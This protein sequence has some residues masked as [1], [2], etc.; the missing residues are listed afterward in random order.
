V[1]GTT[2]RFDYDAEDEPGVTVEIVR[3]VASDRELDYCLL[4][5]ASADPARGFL[6]EADSARADTCA[7]MIEHPNGRPKQIVVRNNVIHTVGDESIQYFT[8]TEEGSSGSPVCDDSWRAIALH[9]SWARVKDVRF[10]GRQAA[11]VNEGTPLTAI[12]KHLGAVWVDS[13]MKARG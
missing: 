3:E 6:V 2:A 8:D 1:R 5:L 4:Q 9:R 12:I 13:V 11:Y 10:Q 7:N